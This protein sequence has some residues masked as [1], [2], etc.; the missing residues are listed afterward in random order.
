[1]SFLRDR[2]QS[3]RSRILISQV[4]PNQGQILESLGLK[5]D[6]WCLALGASRSCGFGTG[7]P[8]IVIRGPWRFHP[9]AMIFR[10][11]A[12][13]CSWP[14]DAWLTSIVNFF[15]VFLHLVFDNIPCPINIYKGPYIVMALFY[16]D[17]N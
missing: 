9:L 7:L 17:L 11:S 1:M 8:L 4:W 10:S 3:I 6:A 2:T 5:L 15:I 13:V 16:L 14:V 12:M